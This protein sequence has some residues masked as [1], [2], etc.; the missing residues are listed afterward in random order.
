M[1][2]DV[3]INN[4][5][6][7]LKKEDVIGRGGDAVIFAIGNRLVAKIY[8]TP[9]TK[10]GRKLQDFLSQHA[11]SLPNNVFHPRDLIHEN[12]GKI[13][14]FT[15]SKLITGCEPIEVL[16]NKN[17]CVKNHINNQSIVQMFLDMANVLNE[18]HKRN[19]II[20][21]IND[22]NEV[23]D[24]SF[25]SVAFLDVDSWQWG[26]HPC[27]VGTEAYLTPELYGKDLSQHPFFL[28]HHDWY[29]FVVLL[30]R[31]ILKIHPFRDGIHNT[32]KSLTNRAER[33]ITALDSDVAYPKIAMS[34]DILSDDIANLMIERLKLQNKDPFPS[35]ALIEYKELLSECPSCHIWFPITRKSCPGCQMKNLI[36][37]RLKKLFKGCDCETL[38]DATGHILYHKVI[39]NVIYCLYEDDE[40]VV[41]HVYENGNT[42]ANNILKSP[43]GS[44]Y[45]MFDKY[46]VICI[47]PREELANLVVIDIEEAK[48]VTVTN[49]KYLA[50]SKVMFATSEKY[51]YRI[52][53]N[54]I[55]KCEMI[56]NSGQ[57]VERIISEAVPN[58]TWFKVCENPI[59]YEIIVGFYR[60]FGDLRWFIVKDENNQVS[61]FDLNLPH[62]LSGESMVDVSIYF[63]ESHAHIIRK[64]KHCGQEYVRIDSVDPNNGKID[65]SK[66]IPLSKNPFYDNIH[67]KI[68][69]GNEII[70]ATNDG[71]VFEN[72]KEDK[73]TTIKDSDDLVT[74][75]DTLQDY[76]N[77]IIAI[78]SN[79]VLLIK[80]KK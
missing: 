13:I 33:G 25:K 43:T 46:L 74:E 50:G 22:R 76:E 44:K 79:K 8:H 36:D 40:N 5:K 52:V 14:G 21:D 24:P 60:V 6:I 70:H 15:M 19:M 7:S 10:R 63:D 9:D 66:L 26:T 39:G 38:I 20:G 51:L 23:L 68:F 1:Y 71:V 59:H 78:T 48:I 72:I 61:R 45:G 67:G 77:N 31:S 16:G 35:E 4:N 27:M 56:G 53:G 64:S 62:L 54:F 30:F 12:T 41:L 47:N 18:I 73:F 34:P 55:M 75:V 57:F 17:F 28:P 42:F 49:T 3:I 65:K 58:Q 69:R 11:S 2:T 29:S 80:P 32:Y 37:M